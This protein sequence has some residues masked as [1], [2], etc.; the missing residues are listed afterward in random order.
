MNYFNFR[1]TTNLEIE[2]VLNGVMVFLVS[3]HIYMN[4]THKAWYVYGSKKL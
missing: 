2:L 4:V 3:P 1:F